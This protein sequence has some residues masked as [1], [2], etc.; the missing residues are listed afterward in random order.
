M[1]TFRQFREETLVK[2]KE[3]KGKKT[4]TV[5]IMPRIRDGE[6]GMVKPVNNE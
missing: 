3:R 4:A 5:E 1:K 6:K 2:D